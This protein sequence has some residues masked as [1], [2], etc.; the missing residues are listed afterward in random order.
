MSAEQERD[1][2]DPVYAAYAAAFKAE[3]ARTRPPRTDHGEKIRALIT[4]AETLEATSM[5]TAYTQAVGYRMAAELL[6]LHDETGISLDRW[7][8]ALE[9]VSLHLRFCGT[10]LGIEPNGA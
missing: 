4:R 8:T 9:F 3:Q 6:Q 10:G 2:A 7:P 1:M 5:P